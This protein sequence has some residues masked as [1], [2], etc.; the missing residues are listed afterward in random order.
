MEDRA[1]SERGVDESVETIPILR[2]SSSPSIL[3]QPSQVM[4]PNLVA[5]SA[6]NAVPSG[7]A[8]DTDAGVQAILQQWQEVKT[9]HGT[10]E[11]TY[12]ECAQAWPLAN[13][14]KLEGM[15]SAILILRQACD[16]LHNGMT[17][18]GSMTDRKCDT[19][20]VQQIVLGG[21][22]SGSAASDNRQ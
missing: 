10:V 2:S 20:K 9:E 16:Y 4:S 18:L 1:A 17:Q 6:S 11:R 14:V 22:D 12:T 13:N 7:S 3:H 19:E 21:D 8:M 5:G 15:E